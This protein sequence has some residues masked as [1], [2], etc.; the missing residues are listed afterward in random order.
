MIPVKP[1]A[2]PRESVTLELVAVASNSEATTG[3]PRPTLLVPIE[4]AV[5]RVAVGDQAFVVDR[6]VFVV[7]PGGQVARVAPGAVVT[8]VAVLG[9]GAPTVAAMVRAHRG[10]GVDAKRLERWW[11]QPTLLPRTVWVHELVHRYVFERH[12]LELHESEAARFLEVELLK[13]LYFLFRDRDEGAERASMQQRFSTAVA[14]AV[15]HVEAHLLEPVSVAAL[16]RAAG[17]SE[18][19]LL[20]AFRREVGLTP[21]TYWRHRKLDATLDLLRSGQHTVAEVAE[22][23]GYENPTAFSDAFARRFGRP[24]SAFKPSQPRV[25]PPP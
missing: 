4:S 5:A 19:A 13:E 10:L 18:S 15:A 2:S 9:F 6:S 14:R 1:S 3:G 16:R 20:R 21:A 7:V 25:R 24:P 8:S 17:T 12:V 11:A 22:R 23:A